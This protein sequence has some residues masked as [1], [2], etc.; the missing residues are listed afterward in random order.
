[1]GSLL[2]IGFFYDIPQNPSGLLFDEE[3]FRQSDDFME[4]WARDTPLE[5]LLTLRRQAKFGLINK[6][7]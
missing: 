3:K 4:L 6:L 2:V 1:M 5:I 7:E